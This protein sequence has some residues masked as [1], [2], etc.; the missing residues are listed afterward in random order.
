MIGSHD[1]FTYLKSTNCLYNGFSRLWRTQPQGYNIEKQYQCGVRMFDVRVA[2]VKNHWQPAHGLATLRNAWSSLGQLAHYVQNAC[3]KAIW[4]LVLER[5]G[6]NDKEQFL[7]EVEQYNLIDNYPNLWRIDIK[8]D[9]SWLGKYGNNNEKL[10]NQGYKFALVNTWES[11]SQE[12]H[13]T[14]TPKNFYKVNL[15]T[16]A[17]KINMRLPFFQTQKA[18]KEEVNSK[19]SLYLIDFATYGDIF[20]CPPTLYNL[21]KRNL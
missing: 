6:K 3:P 15:L 16:E 12:L 8:S 5:G 17:S 10:Y 20:V 4:R 1:T 11:P 14:V 18:F 2:R 7:K 19:D 13:A 9:K 21:H